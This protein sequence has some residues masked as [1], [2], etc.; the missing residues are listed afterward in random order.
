MS[1]FE[2]HL[3]PY[4]DLFACCLMP[5]HFH[6]LLRI[7]D[8]ENFH[9][10]I[11]NFFISYTKAINKVYDRVGSIFQG[12]YKSECV[13]E[14]AYFSRIVMYIHQNPVRVGLIKDMS[15]YQYS[16]YSSFFSIMSSSLCRNEVLE[17]FGGV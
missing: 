14:E 5:N 11:R 7:K 2:G 4:V 6:L 3:G 12:K 10:G 16:L 1:R 17:W 9:R 8:L 13:E 15:A